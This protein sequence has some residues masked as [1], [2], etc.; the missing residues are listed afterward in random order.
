MSC[1]CVFT[2][3]CARNAAFLENAPHS[4]D[5]LFCVCDCTIHNE[6]VVIWVEGCGR[7]RFRGKSAGDANESRRGM[8]G[9]EEMTETTHRECGESGG[10]F[11][12][13]KAAKVKLAAILPYTQS[14]THTASVR[15]R[16]SA[17]NEPQLIIGKLSRDEAVSSA[18]ERFN[19]S[20]TKLTLNCVGNCCR[21]ERVRVRVRVG[22]RARQRS[23][24][25][26]P[27]AT[28]AQRSFRHKLRSSRARRSVR[29]SR[30]ERETAN[31][32]TLF[33]L[34]RI[35]AT[36][37]CNM[38]SHRG[39]IRYHAA[40]HRGRANVVHLAPPPLTN[41]CQTRKQ[42][43]LP[44]AALRVRDRMQTNLTVSTHRG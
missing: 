6:E 12:S 29:R 16:A 31:L 5:D 22:E 9:R 36:I 21:R 39:I 42:M 11:S 2:A 3:A 40:P 1:E 43:C 7:V 33:L 24:A 20:F 34:F 27:C 41:R 30:R 37:M 14:H 28:C 35:T 19:N 13:S 17:S 10:K 4:D 32:N 23:R 26:S 25:C 15:K 38:H 44:L 8:A 18:T